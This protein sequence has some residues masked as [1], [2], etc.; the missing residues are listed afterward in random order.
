MACIYES[1]LMLTSLFS[2]STES[3]VLEIDRRLR[4]ALVARILA[5]PHAR[6]H[7]HF[8]S[9]VRLHRD[10]AV[11]QADLYPRRP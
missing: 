8:F 7:H 1:V 10:P 4:P 5:V 9:L 3:P 11:H 2:S 6:F